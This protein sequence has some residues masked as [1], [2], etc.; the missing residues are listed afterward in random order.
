[1]GRLQREFL[2][3]ELLQIERGGGSIRNDRKED[4]SLKLKYIQHLLDQRGISAEF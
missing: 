2:Q 1:M 3:M 4:D